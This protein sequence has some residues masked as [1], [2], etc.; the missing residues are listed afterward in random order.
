MMQ[1]ASMHWI[2]MRVGLR[3]GMDTTAG[4]TTTS[5]K[6]G[7]WRQKRPQLYEAKCSFCSEV[8]FSI[9]RPLFLL[10]VDSHFEEHFNKHLDKQ[11]ATKDAKS[12]PNKEE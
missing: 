5:V 6:L 4:T 9:D 10:L 1:Y 7:N 11:Q 3:Y 12:H 2:R 8:L